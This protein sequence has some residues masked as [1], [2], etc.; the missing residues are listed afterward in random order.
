MAIMKYGETWIQGFAEAAH[1]LGLSED[2]AKYLLK[3]AAML[4]NADK[5]EFQASF[6][7]AFATLTKSAGIGSNIGGALGGIGKAMFSSPGAATA[8]TLGLGAAGTAGYY[9]LWRPYVGKGDFER[10]AQSIRDAVDYGMLDEDQANIAIT[11]LRKQNADTRLAG[12]GYQ[13][14]RPGAYSWGFNSPA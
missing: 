4:E 11:Q 3:F 2:G 9:G 8:S 12:T 10:K 14:Q 1:N 13:A 6:K 5:P 7:Q